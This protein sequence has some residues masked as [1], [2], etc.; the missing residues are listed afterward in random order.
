MAEHYQVSFTPVRTALSKLTEQGLVIKEANG[1][2]VRARPSAGGSN[3]PAKEVSLPA[4]SRNS[5]EIISSDLVDLSL[6]GEPVYLREE[7][8]AEKYGLSRSAVRNIFHRLAGSGML[9]HIPRRGWRLRVFRQQDLDSFSETR[10]VLELKAL[11][12]ARSH[13]VDADLQ[14]MLDGNRLPLSKDEAPVLDNS[15]HAYFIDKADNFYIK[16]FFERHG[17]Y[18]TLIFSKEG[19]NREAAIETVRDHR[20]VL[21]ALL[22]R[23]WRGARKALSR[24]IRFNHP[25]L[26]QI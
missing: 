23:D 22:D 10:E 8:T 16:D 19:E 25:A 21:K 24:H 11:D 15:L 1:R 14:A 9:D 26:H 20:T 4:P 6:E 2:L 13:F 7:A 5:Y 3:E 17:S 12:L 18:F